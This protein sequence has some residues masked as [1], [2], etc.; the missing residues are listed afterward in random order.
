M[1]G[2][3]ISELPEATSICGNEIVPIVQGDCTKFIKATCLGGGSGGIQS[4][5]AGCGLVGGGCCS[6]VNI[7]I[8]N[9]CFA[10]FNNTTSTMEAFS[11]NWD[12]TYTT[13]QANSAT[14]GTGGG[15]SGG[16]T[17]FRTYGDG[18]I[19]DASAASAPF[20]FVC[21]CGANV[22][23]LLCAFLAM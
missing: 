21:V 23:A 2:I 18:T 1:A 11:G 13:V 5:T 4:I 7:A 22:G 8:D 6:S 19:V 12:S 9:N 20:V 15:G 16:I 10:Q 14:W 3:K 17:G